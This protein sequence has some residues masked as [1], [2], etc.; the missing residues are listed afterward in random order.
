MKLST[1]LSLG[2]AASIGLAMPF[3]AAANHP[4]KTGTPGVNKRQTHQ[5]HRTQQGVRSGQLTKDETKELAG[6]RREIRQE[7]REYRSD[8][9][10]TKEERKDLHQDLNAA[11]KD[12]YQEK[13]DSDTQPGVTPAEP[14]TPG[15]RDPGVNARQANQK[16]RIAEGFK[17]GELTKKE[18]ARLAHKE[19]RLARIEKRLKEDGSLTAE[20]RAKL[21]SYQN[22]LS[23]EIY[24]Q[25]H[26]EQ[27]RPE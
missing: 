9:V 5:K 18:A 27:D 12:I 24:Q 6:T 26:D 25:K 13:H 15:T 10:V 14:G 7:E 4:K 3:E 2:C 16:E 11:S 22:K 1:I 21:Q 19:A 17:S 20:E 23:A 8:G